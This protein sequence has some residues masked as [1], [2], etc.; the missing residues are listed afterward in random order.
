MYIASSIKSNVRELEGALIR[1]AAYA[2]V[3]RPDERNRD[4]ARH[5]A[6][7]AKPIDHAAAC[8]LERRDLGVR[9]S[10]REDVYAH[11]EVVPCPSPTT[12]PCTSH[13]R[14]SRTCAS[15]SVR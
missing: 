3:D 7:M 10:P 15:S 6:R 9:S 14:S 1:L 13:R 2:Y 11:G 12:S 4:P 8:A 5:G